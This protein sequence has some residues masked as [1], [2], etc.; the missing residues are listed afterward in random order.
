MRPEATPDMNGK[1][2]RRPGR[3][4][5]DESWVG[6]V[7]AP[8]AMV[9]LS[10]PARPEALQLARLSAG[11]VAA[12]ARLDYDEVQDLRLAIDELCLS[13]LRPEGLGASRLL[14][15]YSW[16]DHAVEVTCM[17]AS[18]GD[19]HV[20]GPG[21][22]SVEPSEGPVGTRLQPG[23]ISRQILD[24]LVD[25]H[26]VSVSAGRSYGWLRKCR[27]GTAHR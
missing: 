17:V 24:A 20:A 5:L 21:G 13:L 7:E 2:M 9:E 22:T 25:D 27:T 8:G 16:D 11:F 15:S 1:I 26:A 4:R 14:L 19:G 10:I 6:D 3:N 23:A 12:K 18:D